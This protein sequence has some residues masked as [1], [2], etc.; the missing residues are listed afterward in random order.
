MKTRDI[1]QNIAEVK[2]DLLLWPACSTTYSSL[3]PSFLLILLYFSVLLP[4]ATSIYTPD[5]RNTRKH[6]EIT[7]Y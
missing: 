4:S 7:K 2:G 3:S 5:P 1:R 6:V